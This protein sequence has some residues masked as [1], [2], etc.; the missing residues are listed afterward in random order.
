MRMNPDRP[1]SASALLLS[2]S[3]EKLEKILRENADEPL[4]R[5]LAAKL[6]G[7]KWETTLSLTAEI[8]RALCAHPGADRDGTMRR[9]FQ[10]L[11]IAVNEEFTALNMLLRGVPALLK[12]GGRLAILTFHSG[13]DRR[14]K[15]SFAEGMRHGLYSAVSTNVVR[16]SAEE[17][18]DNPR[19]KS[20]K[21]RWAVKAPNL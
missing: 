8:D 10:A 17:I 7:R 13:E 18:R 3:P 15:Q 21:L 4:A 2:I 20:A 1:V 11:R 16:P 9:V 5:E 12:S 6:A 19:A 14:V